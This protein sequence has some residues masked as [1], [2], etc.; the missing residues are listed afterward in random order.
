MGS[1]SPRRAGFPTQ[2]PVPAVSPSSGRFSPRPPHVPGGRSPP[3]PLSNPPERASAGHLPP[4]DRR[5]K[6]SCN[7]P[8]PL[9]RLKLLWLEQKA[10]TSCLELE[11]CFPPRQ[12]YAHRRPG[13]RGKMGGG[14]LR[15]PSCT[16]CAPE[17]LPP[18]PS[19]PAGGGRGLEAR[20]G[21]QTPNKTRRPRQKGAFQLAI[22]NP[23][24]GA[25]SPYAWRDV[26]RAGGPA[27][28]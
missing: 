8:K 17:A 22:R 26:R 19:G 23:P 15:R 16:Y 18:A 21:A 14:G 20:P 13:G 25:T 9:L 4:G 7:G 3:L 24:A 1:R 6:E 28:G 5:G 12:L 11:A 2:T 27:G 10:C